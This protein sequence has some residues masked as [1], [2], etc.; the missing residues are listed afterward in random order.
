MKIDS[1][2][3]NGFVR[4]KPLIGMFEAGGCNYVL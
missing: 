1:I 4:I 2:L 3:I